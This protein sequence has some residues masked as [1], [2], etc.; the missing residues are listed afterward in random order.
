MNINFSDLHKILIVAAM[1]MGDVV[2][3]TP[4]TRALKNRFPRTTIDLLVGPHAKEAAQHNPYCDNILVCDLDH[5]QQGSAKMHDIINL[6]KK[7]RYDLALTLNYDA[8]GAMLAWLSG[9]PH[10]I[11]FGGDAQSKFLTHVI[12]PPLRLLHESEKQLELLKPLGITEQNSSIDFTISPSALENIT[13]KIGLTTHRPLIVF[14]PFSSHLHKDWT[15]DGWIALINYFSAK[16]QCILIGC[17]KDRPS[18]KEINDQANSA[19]LVAAGHLTLGE[20]AALIKTADL[21]ITVDTG[22]MHIAQAFTTPVIALM[23]PTHSRVWGPRNKRDIIIRSHT[24]ACSPCWQRFK[25]YATFEC[26]HHTCMVQ[27]TPGE[28]IKAADIRLSEIS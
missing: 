1:H 28:I 25:N 20:S 22:P 13:G 5:H 17:E 3:S 18:L 6:L 19:A 23:G 9:A 4:V 2:L 15:T 16:A 21:F 7:E 26:P 14:C 27:I 8:L 11:G 12:A 24:C 10:R